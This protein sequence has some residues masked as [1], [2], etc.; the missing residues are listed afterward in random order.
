MCISL[1]G[2]NLTV[3]G[4]KM[5]PYEGA[6]PGGWGVIAD[7]AGPMYNNVFV[8]IPENAAGKIWGYS[9]N[10]A[11]NYTRIPQVT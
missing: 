11:A 7:A 2:H 3:I 6:N 10:V 8:N 4:T 9:G 1:S 5:L